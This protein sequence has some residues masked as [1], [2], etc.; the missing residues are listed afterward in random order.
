MLSVRQ[1]SKWVA[2]VSFDAVV[3]VDKQFPSFSRLSLVSVRRHRNQWIANYIRW[4]P[5]VFCSSSF[6]FFLSVLV[7]LCVWVICR[8]ALVS[9]LVEL[10]DEHV[11]LN[12][13]LR[14]TVGSALSLGSTRSKVTMTSTIENEKFSLWS[15][16]CYMIKPVG[17]PF[18]I[19]PC[20]SW[21][22]WPARLVHE[23]CR[24][25]RK[26][27]IVEF[28]GATRHDWIKSKLRVGKR[29]SVHT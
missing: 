1:S 6:S 19:Q 5:C 7:C 3:R 8:L 18:V 13:S 28:N 4:C 12:T 10:I 2:G 29:A 14:T 26:R 16:S 27:K 22:K 9:D 25:K 21:M 24:E 11:G 17:V 20:C 15:V 23:K